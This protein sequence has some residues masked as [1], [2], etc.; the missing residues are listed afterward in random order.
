MGNWK[1]IRNG[2]S[3]SMQNPKQGSPPCPPCIA[4][5]PVLTLEITGCFFSEPKPPYEYFQYVATEQSKRGTKQS[6]WVRKGI[7]F[8]H[9]MK[10]RAGKAHSF[11][12]K[13]REAA[14]MWQ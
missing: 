13:P 11:F 1:S 8:K 6:S 5:P 10:C 12:L 3:L 2:S 4:A 14:V 9:E 7:S